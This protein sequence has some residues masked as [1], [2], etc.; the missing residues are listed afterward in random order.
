MRES[1]EFQV[2]AEALIG[3]LEESRTLARTRLVIARHLARV[4]GGDDVHFDAGVWRLE[5]KSGRVGAVRP[6]SRYA[7]PRPTFMG[8]QGAGRR[9]AY[10]IDASD[11]MLVPLTAA[12]KRDLRPP[13]VCPPARYR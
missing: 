7:L 13:R 9:V 2:A 6:G 4:V 3:Q 12:E 11:S 5:M 8:V 10:V 1:P